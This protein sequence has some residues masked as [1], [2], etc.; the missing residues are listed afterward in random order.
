MEA[1]VLAFCVEA[2]E[3]SDTHT[4][5]VTAAPPRH[6]PP[7]F[8]GRLLS[9]LLHAHQEGTQP[10]Q[11]LCW[12]WTAG[13]PLRP[14]YLLQS[15]HFSRSSVAATV[16]GEAPVLRGHCCGL[17]GHVLLGTHRC[18]PSGPF[19]PS[20]TA[21]SHPDHSPPVGAPQPQLWSVCPR[22]ATV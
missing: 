12:Q 14:C 7:R 21:V 22:S 6:Q 2:Q 3:L 1:A 20:P 15:A 18:L 11:P 16:A 4:S 19:G 13:C 10:A 17:C 5:R 8:C 9:P